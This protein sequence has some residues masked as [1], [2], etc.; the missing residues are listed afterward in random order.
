MLSKIMKIIFQN[1][2]SLCTALQRPSKETCSYKSKVTFLQREKSGTHFNSSD[3]LEI[4]RY[5][6]ELTFA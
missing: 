5:L 4:A 6:R 2:V 1:Y 3:D